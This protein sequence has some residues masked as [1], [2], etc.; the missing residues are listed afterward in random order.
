MQERILDALRTGAHADALALA[1]EAVAATPHDAT[2]YALLA[3]AERANGNAAA[4]L[5]AINR[6]VLL[7]PEDANLHFQRAG[8]LL[9][10]YRL[11]EAQAALARTLD[12]D[13]NQFPAYIMQ[14]Q[15]A[16]GRG[17]L[18]EAE[19]LQ[20]YAARI[21]PEHP[22]VRTI[23]GMIALRRG[24]STRALSLLTAASKQMPDDL[25]VLYALG[26]AHMEQGHLAFAESAFR[27]IVEASPDQHGLRGLLADVVMRQGRADEARQIV[28]PLLDNPETSSHS[29]KRLTAGLELRL[30]HLDEALALLRASIEQEPRDP[31]TWAMAADLWRRTGRLEEGREVTDAALAKHPEA[32]PLW[33]LRI[34]LEPTGSDEAKAVV[35]RWLAL[36]ADDVNALEAQMLMMEVRGD[37]EARDALAQRIVELE[38]GRSSAETRVFDRMV[39]QTPEA[40][41][42]HVQG[43]I[44]KT[45]DEGIKRGLMAW[46]GIAQDR[47]GRQA[48]AVRTWHAMNSAEAMIRRPLT[49]PGNA[50]GAWPE[51]ADIATGVPPLAYLWGVPGSGV[52]KIA[53]VIGHAGYPLRADRLGPNPPRDAIQD[54][55][56]IAAFNDGTLTG[57]QA[58]AQWRSALALRGVPNGAIIDWL[59]YWDNALLHMIRPLQPE[60]IVLIALRDPR[61]MLLEWLAFGSPLQYAVPSA[62][63][64]ALWIA[65]QLQHVL[66]ITRD[67]LVSHKVIRTDRVLDDLEAFAGEV[68]GGLGLEQILIPPPEM[69]GR[70]RFP[71][72]HWRQYAG[73]LAEPFALLSDVAQAFGYPAD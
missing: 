21:A 70:D 50:V 48:D 28:Q 44:D 11:D 66:V 25:Q 24:D 55:A 43:L 8:F 4:A 60:A 37:S 36:D 35:D 31:D 54:P 33:R 16:F 46:L 61:D 69:F 10:E 22:W 41:I 49:V 57:E 19:R 5:Q 6:A 65:R 29:L 40:A 39:S 47:A 18:D 45:Q 51:L 58:L 23:E 63:E 42:A 53:T 34:T 52:E 12:L 9:A 30:G 27:R 3:H 1:R 59:P 38:P 67:L 32:A 64:A 20:R 73:P 7:G 72:G 14:A 15:M 13:P 68:G 17:D 56:C 26:F 2:N 71:P 62:N